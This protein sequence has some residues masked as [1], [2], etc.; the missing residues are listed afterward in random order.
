MR[1]GKS[2]AVCAVN[3][4]NPRPNPHITDSFLAYARGIR[5]SVL[6]MISIQYPIHFCTNI[7]CSA[8]F[9]TFHICHSLRPH[10]IPPFLILQSTVPLPNSSSPSLL[11]PCS[12]GLHVYF[13]F[14][15]T[16]TNFEWV[17]LCPTS[18]PHFLVVNTT[19]R[20]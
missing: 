3:L 17:P 7:P 13:I 19:Y 14:C 16:F 5:T 18:T 6:H 9:L 10:L 4:R 15:L 11:F 1:V 12:N 8:Y 20:R 2:A